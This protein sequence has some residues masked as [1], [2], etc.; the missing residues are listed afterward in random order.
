[1][2]MMMMIIMII[3]IVLTIKSRQR[4]VKSIQTSDCEDPVDLEILLSF[5]VNL[6][7]FL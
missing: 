3:M 1:M 2:M 5:M 6:V 4:W 7:M